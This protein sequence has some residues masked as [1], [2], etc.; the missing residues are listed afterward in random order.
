ME[1]ENKENE[2]E[3]GEE[4]YKKEVVSRQRGERWLHWWYNQDGWP[5][6]ENWK[7]ECKENLNLT[8]E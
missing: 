7:T 2:S 8:D 1:E 4:E 5:N 6:I 3:R